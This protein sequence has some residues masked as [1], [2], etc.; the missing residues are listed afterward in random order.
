MWILLATVI[1]S[2]ITFFGMYFGNHYLT[3]ALD[4]RWLAEQRGLYAREEAQRIRNLYGKMAQSAA[5]LQS[6]THER[7]FVSILDGTVEQR[8]KRH[9]DA[10][11][12]ADNEIREVGGQLIVEP[13]ARPVREKFIELRGAFDRYLNADNSEPAGVGR[14]EK[15][16]ELEQEIDRLALEV[17]DLAE[18]HLEHLS[19]PPSLPKRQRRGWRPTPRDP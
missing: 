13:A 18:R 1:G 14:V 17:Q 11:L 2:V 3:E 19:T 8:N 4:R 9:A 5:T 6:I 12:V 16:R 15:V 10:L 7:T